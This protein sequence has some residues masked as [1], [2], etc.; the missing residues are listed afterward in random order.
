ATHSK[1]LHQF[2]THPMHSPL[3]IVPNRQHN[4]SSALH[5]K[6]SERC[7]AYTRGNTTNERAFGST[8]TPAIT[9]EIKPNPSS[10]TS[11]EEITNTKQI[12]YAF[13]QPAEP[14]PDTPKSVPPCS[15]WL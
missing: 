7:K 4:Q 9:H 6:T 3:D 15:H 8:E 14:F 2:T 11:P 12:K 10:Y 5:Q 1:R 13:S